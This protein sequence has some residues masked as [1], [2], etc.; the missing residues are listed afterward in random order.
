M[1]RIIYSALRTPDGTLLVSR[2]RHDYV[3]HTDANGK[4]YMLDGGLDYVRSSAHGDEDYITIHVDDDWELV[5]THMLWGTFG[6][7]G[8]EP[9]RQVMLKEM[10]SDHIRAVLENCPNIYPQY[11][12]AFEKELK[13]RNE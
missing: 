3:T 6:K 7:N 10:T 8:D 1:G 12:E 5:R 2:S 9:Y 11:R 13:F 4:Q